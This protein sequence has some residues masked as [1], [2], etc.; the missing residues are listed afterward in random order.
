MLG[1]V[2]TCVLPLLSSHTDFSR[3]IAPEL[4]A[5]FGLTFVAPLTFSKLVITGSKDLKN[6][7]EWEDTLTARDESWDLLTQG[8]AGDWVRPLPPPSATNHHPSILAVSS[9]LLRVHRRQTT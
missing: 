9:P 5:H 2:A 4:D 8:E 1:V 6:V 7:Q 3:S